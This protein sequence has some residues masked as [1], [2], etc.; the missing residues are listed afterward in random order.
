MESVLGLQHAFPTDESHHAY[1]YFRNVRSRLGYDIELLDVAGDFRQVIKVPDDTGEFFY[2]KSEC[3]NLLDNDLKEIVVSYLRYILERNHCST[4]VKKFAFIEYLSREMTKGIHIHE[5]MDSVSA[6]K[7]RNRSSFISSFKEFL[8]FAILHEYEALSLDA[9]EEFQRLRDYSGGKNNHQ[10]L[11]MMDDD[12]G[13]FSKEE[14]SVLTSQVDNDLLPIG[15]RLILDLCLSFGFR[16]MQM[17][18][19]RRKDFI[20]DQITGI[21]YL[22][23]PRTKNRSRDRRSQLSSR[24]LSERTANLIQLYISVSPTPIGI[25]P[26]ELPIFISPR[27]RGLEADGNSAGSHY[28]DEEE[29]T[30]SEYFLDESKLSVV[31]HKSVSKIHYMLWSGEQKLPLSPRTGMKFNLSAYRFRYTVGTQAVMSGCTPEEVADL[32]DHQSTNC[33]KHYFRFTHEMWEILEN[34]TLSRL[35]QKQFTAAW[36]REGDLQGNV[37]SQVCEPKNFNVIGK[38]ASNLICFEEPA[39]TCYSCSKFCP[40]KNPSAHEAALEGLIARKNHL[41]M[42]ST[43]NVVSVI[44]QAIA[45]CHAAI[46]YSEGQNVILINAKEL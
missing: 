36:M 32:L 23:V 11:F 42:A 14:I 35:E 44:D 25:D 33:V 26:A 24:I 19:L 3:L 9:Y 28:W 46:A 41:A 7:S 10:Y 15:F 2:L 17:S 45:G 12:R 4:V 22:N 16:P 8:K 6:S 38:C 21:Y 20:K 29:R 30:S 34:A 39:I 40:N 37:F 43:A 31:Y 18:L 13:P 1:E 27:L 5:L